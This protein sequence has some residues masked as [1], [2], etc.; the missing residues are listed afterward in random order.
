MMR[1]YFISNGTHIKIGK[2]GKP[3]ETRLVALQTGSHIPLTVLRVVDGDREREFHLKFSSSRVLGEWFALSP[4]LCKAANV[5]GPFFLWLA[6][7]DANREHPNDFASDFTHD[8]VRDENFPK[9]STDYRKLS[10]YLSFLGACREA[11]IG[12]FHAYREWQWS[13]RRAR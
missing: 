12:L 13:V 9:Y 6:A 2:T 5:P 3:I 4:E 10:R 11:R 1:T 8:A 7:R